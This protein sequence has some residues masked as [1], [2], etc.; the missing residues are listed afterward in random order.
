MV[1]ASVSAS[2]KS[3]CA[4]GLT[5]SVKVDDLQEMQKPL[6]RTTRQRYEGTGEEAGY[7]R[8]AKGARPRHCGIGH[9]GPKP[10][11]TAE[12]T[13]QEQQQAADQTDTQVR[14]EAAAAP[15][16]AAAPD[17]YQ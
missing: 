3:D 16:P 8:N 14:Q 1:S 2:K 12:K 11:T 17:S 13:L 5:V 9:T 6:R 7:G 4:A 10:D 15:A